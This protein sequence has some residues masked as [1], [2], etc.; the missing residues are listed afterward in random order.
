MVRNRTVGGK[1]KVKIKNITNTDKKIVMKVA[2]VP[3]K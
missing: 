1:S 3:K 2:K